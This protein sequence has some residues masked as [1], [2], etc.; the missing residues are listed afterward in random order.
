V[1]LRPH[2]VAYQGLRSNIHVPILALAQLA[3]SARSFQHMPEAVVHRD[4]YPDLEVDLW[5]I[6]DGRIVIGEAKISN[7]LKST[8]GKEAQR[9]AALKGLIE[10]LSADEFV[11]ATTGPG[12]C[13]R[14]ETLVNEKLAPAAKITWL[15]NLR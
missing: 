6:V 8:K 9:C 4:G 1:V 11:M 14:T 2:E 12:W 10:D 15:T 7:R 3:G 5:T 13:G